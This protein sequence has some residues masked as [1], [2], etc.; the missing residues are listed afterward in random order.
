MRRFP[1]LEEFI[2]FCRN[3]FKI[4]ILE[5]YKKKKNNYLGVFESSTIFVNFTAEYREPRINRAFALEEK[6]AKKANLHSFPSTSRA[7][8][9]T[10]LM[11]IPRAEG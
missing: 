8:L 4:N 6:D 5:Y 10:T 1:L 3:A 9:C 2:K 11:I 7:V